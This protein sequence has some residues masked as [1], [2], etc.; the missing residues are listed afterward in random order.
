M[1]TKFLQLILI[2]LLISGLALT[3]ETLQTFNSAGFKVKCNCILKAN[4]VFI[5]MA[6][7]QGINNVIAAYV[8]AENEDNPDIGVIININVYDQSSNYQAISPQYHAFF[9]KRYLESYA[10]NLSNAG[11]KYNYIT[12]QGV[13]AVEYTFIQ[14]GLPAK[15]IY[16]L[17]NQKSFLI[18]TSTRNN[19]EYNFSRIK[20]SF[21]LL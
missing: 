18:Q 8:C 14:M 3:Q 7:Q 16:F 15:A 21:E 12:S 20:K 1:K 6:K 5:Q 11:I 10:T 9:E 17:K 4:T 2:G 13:T 19:L